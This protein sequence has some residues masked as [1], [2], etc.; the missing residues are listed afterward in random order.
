M[1][2]K[3]FENSD[4]ITYDIVITTVPYTE[5]GLPLMAPAVL[6]PIA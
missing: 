6:K 3:C 4:N 2:F 1:K 5:S